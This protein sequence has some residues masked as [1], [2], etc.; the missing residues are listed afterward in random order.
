MEN[1]IYTDVRRFARFQLLEY[2]MV[3]LEDGS[4]P[5]RAMVVDIGLGGAQLRSKEQ[6]PVGEICNIELG[7]ED[8]PTLTLRGE[9]RFSSKIP[10]SEL[11]ATGFKFMPET[12]EERAAV[13][14][15]VHA[16]FQ[17]IEAD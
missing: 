15:Y 4:E 14:A 17:A 6:M 1:Q 13:A 16:V 12:H 8:G 10:H 9:V 11:H 7:Q 3:H 2:A 5:F